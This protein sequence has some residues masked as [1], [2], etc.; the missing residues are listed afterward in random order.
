MRLSSVLLAALLTLSA[1]TACAP[2][3]VPS[4]T[5]AAGAGSAAAAQRTWEANRPAAYA[6]GLEISCFC[7]H[8]GQY[9]VEVRNGQI[10]SVRDATTGQPAAASRVEWIIT[11]DRLFEVI[12]QA[13]QAGTPVRAEYHPQLGYPVEAEVG[14]LANDSGTLYR[15]T[16]LR[17]L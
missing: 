10:T 4:D 12:G 14:L 17:A 7:I 5:P 6:Y 16:N 13:S 15:I 3:A 9:A 8:R 2:A 1:T 11:V